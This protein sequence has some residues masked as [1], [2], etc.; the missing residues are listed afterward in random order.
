MGSWV[1]HPLDVSAFLEQFE[2]S[3][4]ETTR[5]RESRRL[6]ALVWLFLL[7]NEETEHPRN[8]P[9]AVERQADRVLELLA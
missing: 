4:A 7:A 3:P 5:L 8:P 6:L 9:G 1:E 2:L